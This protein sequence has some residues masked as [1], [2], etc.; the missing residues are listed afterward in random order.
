MDPNH[1]GEIHHS[2]VPQLSP[3]NWP[4]QFWSMRV[5]CREKW[6]QQAGTIEI[7]KVAYY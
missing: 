3:G 5:R 1:K 7:Q 4:K 6:K 2:S